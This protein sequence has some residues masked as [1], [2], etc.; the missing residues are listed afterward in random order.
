MRLKSAAAHS[1]VSSYKLHTPLGFGEGG[2]RK[3]SK[4]FAAQAA[5]QD[6]RLRHKKIFTVR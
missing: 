4:I 1:T 5:S 6:I 2:V 3:N